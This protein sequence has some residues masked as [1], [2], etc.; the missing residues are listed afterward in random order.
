MEKKENLI[1]YAAIV[2]FADKKP[3]IYNIVKSPG[4]LIN[5]WNKKKDGIYIDLYEKKPHSDLKEY[6]ETIYLNQF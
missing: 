4:F 6:L 5:Y 3:F 2:Y 1:R